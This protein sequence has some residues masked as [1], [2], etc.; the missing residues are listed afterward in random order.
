MSLTVFGHKP[1]ITNRL[2]QWISFDTPQGIR[3]DSGLGNDL[4][5]VGTPTFASAPFPKASDRRSNLSMGGAYRF[6]SGNYFKFNAVPNLTWTAGQPYSICVWAYPESGHGSFPQIWTIRSGS[7]I[8]ILGINISTSGAGYNVLWG[9]SGGPYSCTTE[10]TTPTNNTWTHVAGTFSAGATQ[11]PKIYVNGV[12]MQ[13]GVARATS[14]CVP[15]ANNSNSNIG[16]GGVNGNSP[17]LGSLHDLRVYACELSN[18]DILGIMAEAIQPRY[19]AEFPI[20]QAAAAS[21]SVNLL[22]GLVA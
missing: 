18:A 19:D 11:T 5:Q 20:I 12:L 16:D 21:S 9:P 15:T 2:K 22:R 14:T 7:A 13:T 3:D 10:N 1:L 17:W 4:L 6:S 8:V